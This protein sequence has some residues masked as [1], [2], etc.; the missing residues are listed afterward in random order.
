MSFIGVI[1]SRKCFENIKRKIEEKEKGKKIN[2]LQIN[3]R[4]IDNVKNVRF[5]TII[6]ED[7]I[8]KFKEKREMIE[9]FCQEAQYVM[10]NSDKNPTLIDQEETDRRITYGLNQK[11]M[12]TISSI[13]DTDIL[14]YWQKRLLDKEGRIIEIEERKLKKAE[15]KALSTYEILILY[16]FFQIYDKSIIEEIQEKTNFFEQ[17]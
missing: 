7:N 15:K 6:M 13:R 11:A 14:V 2:L 4:S 3:L 10:I 1:A 8:E 17:N 5:E 9:K 16:T 12:V